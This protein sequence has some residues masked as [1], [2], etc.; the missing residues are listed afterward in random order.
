VL[1]PPL[2]SLY[3]REVSMAPYAQR[4]LQRRSGLGTLWLP[5]VAV[6]SMAGTIG[7]ALL[8][9]PLDCAVVIGDGKRGPLDMAYIPGGEF[10]MGNERQLSQP[11]ERP[12]HRVHV[13]AFWMDRHHV[14][15]AE[16]RQFVEATGYVT[17]AEHTSDL[18]TARAQ[19]LLHGRKLDGRQRVSGAMVFI[20]SDRPVPLTDLSQWWVFVPG[21]NWRHPQ[22]PQ[23]SIVGRDDHPVVQVS[24]EDAQ[25]YARWIGKR[26]PTEAEWEFAARGGIE[27]ADFP[28]GDQFEPDGKRMANTFVGTFPVVTSMILI[29]GTTPIG[30]YPPNG[31]GLYDMA[32]NAWQWVA[33]WYRSDAFKRDATNA[34]VV[35]PHGPNDSFD[36]E[37]RNYPATAP[38]RVMR[39]GSFL[40][41]ERYC[42]SYRPSARR[43]N[44]PLNPTSHIGFRL[45]MTEPDWRLAKE[46]KEQLESMKKL[47]TLNML[48]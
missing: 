7:F 2:S 5:L 14:T 38:A 42:S 8:E 17:T 33:D 45:V 23:S 21:A 12:A 28:W 46:K 39:G 27:Q 16:F 1:L 24:Y 32:G 25:A 4:G 40:C 15:N 43:G 31:Y 37:A 29:A 47:A 19:R 9:N 10:I 30:S 35:N 20:G 36:A 3:S 41:S 26:L 11:N 22:G 34:P 6:V 18:N 13:D 44:D 48:P